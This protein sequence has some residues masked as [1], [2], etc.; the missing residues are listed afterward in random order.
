M[1]FTAK[2]TSLQRRP[3][4]SENFM[5]TAEIQ[6]VTMKDREENPGK[7]GMP[8]PDTTKTGDMNNLLL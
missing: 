3:V 8:M 7:P 1:Y 4:V 2:H 6:T 5:G